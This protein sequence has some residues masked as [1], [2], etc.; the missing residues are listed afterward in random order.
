MVKQVQPKVT[1]IKRMVAVNNLTAASN[2]ST[3]AA[4]GSASFAITDVPNY[5]DFTN[6]FDQF[7]I[8]K[9]KLDFF[10]RLTGNTSNALPAMYSIFHIAVDHTDVS[11]PTSVN[12][13]FQYDNHK[14]VQAYKPFSL[15]FTPAAS[16]AYYGTTTALG[17]GPKAGSW[18]D[19]KAGAST[20]HYGIKWGWECN[21]ATATYIECRAWYFCEFR[22]PN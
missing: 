8:V 11:T 10:P 22:E 19:S 12:D 7:R 13:L 1:K 2:T 6:L 21:N 20:A 4:F 14:T 9:I 17:Y 5:S 18:I 16:A 3:Y 15:T